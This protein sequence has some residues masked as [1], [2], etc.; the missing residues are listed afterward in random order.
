MLAVGPSGPQYCWLL[1]GNWYFKTWILPFLVTKKCDNNG[2]C[3]DKYI[4]FNSLRDV[5]M[6]SPILQYSFAFATCLPNDTEHGRS[7]LKCMDVAQ[8]SAVH[9]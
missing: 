2:Y 3:Q 8:D 1:D 9:Y 6:L 7:F 5:E 4:R